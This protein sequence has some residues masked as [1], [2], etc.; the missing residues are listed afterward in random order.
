MIG[1]AYSA[2]TV[3]PITS[4]DEIQPGD[5]L[6]FLGRVWRYRGSGINVTLG[7]P[8]ASRGYVFEIEG[9][10][11]SHSFDEY[12]MRLLIAQGALSRGEVKQI[13]LIEPEPK[14]ERVGCGDP[15]CPICGSL[16]S[17]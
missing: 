4:L 8:G 14:P 12:E 9:F 13:V 10:H 5:N 15:N 6:E 16:Y 7:T 2:P 17:A 3:L 1:S 11:Y